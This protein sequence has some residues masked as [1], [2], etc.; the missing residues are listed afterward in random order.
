MGRTESK[1]EADRL[2]YERMEANFRFPEKTATCPTP[3]PGKNVL[4]SDKEER[5][6]GGRP[7]MSTEGRVIADASN[8]DGPTRATLRIARMVTDPGPNH[9]R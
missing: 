4:D 2:Q 5:E 9:W 7:I 3:T 1:P 8:R 6:R